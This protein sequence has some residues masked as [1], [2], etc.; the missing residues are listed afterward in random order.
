MTPA[1]AHTRVVNI[2]GN[3]EHMLKAFSEL[4][5]SV[6]DRGAIPP[7]V[8]RGFLRDSGIIRLQLRVLLKTYFR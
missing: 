7:D 4:T 2:I 5:A 3:A 8:A 1:Q 6:R